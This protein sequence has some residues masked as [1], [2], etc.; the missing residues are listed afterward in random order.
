MSKLE[1]TTIN[2]DQLMGVLGLENN[3]EFNWMLTRKEDGLVKKSKA[4][5][6][7][8]WN[9]DGTFNSEHDLPSVGRSLLM[10]P[11]NE[12]FSWQTTPIIALKPIENGYEFLTKNS[13]YILKEINE[14]SV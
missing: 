7:I 5:M 1:Q 4:I 10:S 9:E 12:F 3:E 8:Q 11:F 6:W 2:I 13:T 14:P